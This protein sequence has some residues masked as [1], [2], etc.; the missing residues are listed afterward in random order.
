MLVNSVY[1][2]AK[3]IAW[4]MAIVKTIGW[5]KRMRRGR[6]MLDKSFVVR[7]RLSCPGYVYSVPCSL[8]ALMQRLARITGVY[9]SRRK[10]KPRRVLIV[11]TIVRI[12][13]TLNNNIS[14]SQLAWTECPCINI[15]SPV[16][17]LNNHAAEERSEGWA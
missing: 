7:E 9:V 6:C 13:K 12:Q 8:D 4:Y 3:M 15:P 10:R 17:I 5:V 14:K 11:Q 2:L 16:E 1:M